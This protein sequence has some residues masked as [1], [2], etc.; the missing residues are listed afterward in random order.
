M[1]SRR[2]PILLGWRLGAALLILLLSGACSTP[3]GVIRGST[4]AV[5]RAATSNV[6]ATGRP[7][8]WSKQVLSRA[9]L[10][11]WFETDPEAG[12]RELRQ[13]LEPAVVADVLFALA[14]LSFHH[15]EHTGQRPH[16]LA[17]AVYAYAFLFPTDI[18]VPEVFDPRRHLAAELY[19]RGLAH[20]LA[21]PDGDDV[22]LEGG[23]QPLPFGQLD[24]SVEPSGFAWETYRLVRFVP[25]GRDLKKLAT[26]A[27]A[28]PPK[29]K[30]AAEMTRDVGVTQLRST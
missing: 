15:A 13:L 25:V 10:S 22:V 20:G 6:L 29:P 30:T 23:Q 2:R 12:L 21:R 17:A 16:Y 11:E 9:G 18:P 26:E 28:A 8:E 4:Q 27:A 3:I 7:S 24:L 14:E 1:A 5:Y 19:D